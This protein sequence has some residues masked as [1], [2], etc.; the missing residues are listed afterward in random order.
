MGVFSGLWS[1]LFVPAHKITGGLVHF[2]KVL[3]KIHFVSSGF[4]DLYSWIFGRVGRKL[5]HL[6]CSKSHIS[7]IVIFQARPRFEDERTDK[8]KH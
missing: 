1:N 6:M 8:Q 2:E 3:I 5:L 4:A 7:Q